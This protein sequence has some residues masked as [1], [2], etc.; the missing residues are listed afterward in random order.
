MYNYQRQHFDEKLRRN[1]YTTNRR[2]CTGGQKILKERTRGGR[3]EK[4]GSVSV[5]ERSGRRSDGRRKKRGS[6][7]GNGSG[8]GRE[9]GRKSVNETESVIGIDTAGTVI[10]TADIPAEHRK[11]GEADLENTSDLG[12]RSGRGGAVGAI[13]G[14]SVWLISPAQ[15]SIVV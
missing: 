10:P 13:W 9:R 2:N 3:R 12:A 6:G 7:K 15:E 5:S 4:S 1:L 14:A 8:K 11:G